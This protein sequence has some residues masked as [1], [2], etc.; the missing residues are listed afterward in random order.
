MASPAGVRTP[1]GRGSAGFP[2]PYGPAVRL[3][4]VCTGNLCRSPVAERLTLAR[5]TRSLA[6][7]PERSRVEIL[8]AGERAEA[9][10][11][12][13][14]RSATAL[15]ALGGDPSGFRSRR[16]TAELAQSADLVLTMTRKQRATVLGLNPRGLRRT[17]TLAEAADLAGLAD[18]TGLALTPL[19]E[20]APEF[21][22]RLDAARARRQGT[23]ADDIADP[24]GQR[25]AVHAE[26]ADR[27]DRALTPLA[28]V[29]FTSVRTQLAVPLPV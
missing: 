15:Q 20:R 29:L 11:P 26:V 8:S 7:S 2:E 5:A 13:D 19:D 24:I 21:G 18:L 17:F 4:F 28:D 1:T 23:G 27:I 10:A 9:G 22:R 6:D 3:L 25:A 16:L 12:M 14:P